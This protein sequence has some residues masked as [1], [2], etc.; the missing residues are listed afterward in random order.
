MMIHQNGLQ[1]QQQQID[2]TPRLKE[3]A[4]Y[5]VE[6]LLDACMETKQAGNKKIPRPPAEFVR[7]FND[8]YLT[9]FNVVDSGVPVH[10]YETKR[11]EGS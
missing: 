5:I 10:E 6:T 4:P 1:Q 8:T 11:T 2:T 9:Y 7:A 3:A